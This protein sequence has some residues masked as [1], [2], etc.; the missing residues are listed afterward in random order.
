MFLLIHMLTSRRIN[1]IYGPEQASHFVI[2]RSFFIALTHFT[3]MESLLLIY[4]ARDENL[5]AI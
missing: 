4:D 2:K 5:N 1:F 3:A